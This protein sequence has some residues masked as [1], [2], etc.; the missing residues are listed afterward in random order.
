MTNSDLMLTSIFISTAAA[1]GLHFNLTGDAL[2][3][4]K[5]R[6]SPTDVE[7]STSTV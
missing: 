5:T 3:A 6:T 1:A 2:P 4:V 7:Q